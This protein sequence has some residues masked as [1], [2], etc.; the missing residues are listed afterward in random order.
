M[1]YFNKG[2]KSNGVDRSVLITCSCNIAWVHPWARFSI[3]LMMRPA[4][5]LL[6]G[7][8]KGRKWIGDG[9]LPLECHWDELRSHWY[10]SRTLSP[11]P[12]LTHWVVLRIRILPLGGCL[13]PD[14][15]SQQPISGTQ[16]LTLVNC[17]TPFWN[18]VP[19]VMSYTISLKQMK[20][21]EF[22]CFYSWIKACTFVGFHRACHSYFKRP[23]EIAVRNKGCNHKL[24]SQ[25]MSSLS[26]HL[27]EQRAACRVSLPCHH[28]D[29]SWH[30]VETG[31]V[32]RKALSSTLFPEL[33]LL[34]H[35]L[36]DFFFLAVVVFFSFS[37]CC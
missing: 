14:L 9:H 17:Q 5:P 2:N 22:C 21:M 28:C 16:S 36:W 20:E 31:S 6:W 23:A 35:M 27:R 30:S 19:F 10:P 12:S 37:N 1:G 25:K 34:L 18:Q 3:N 33:S 8:Q 15:C 24:R 11:R 29:D 4:Q 32:S 26:I 7:C 13:N